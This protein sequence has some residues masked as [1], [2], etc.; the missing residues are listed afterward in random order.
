M[1]DKTFYNPD[2]DCGEASQSGFVVLD[3]LLGRGII[4]DGLNVSPESFNDIDDPRSIYGRPSDQFEAMTMAKELN[5]RGAQA[6]K[7]HDD[8]KAA[9]EAAK[10]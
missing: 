7:L 5:K 6:Q 8:R 4:P 3:D 1:L 2:T 10:V 9:D